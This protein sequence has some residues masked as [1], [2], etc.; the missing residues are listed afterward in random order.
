MPFTPNFVDGIG[1]PFVN[2]EMFELARQ[3]LDGA[4]VVNQEQTAAALRLVVERNRVVPE[5]A[6]ATSVAAALA[7]MAGG[8]KIAASSR[9]ATSTSPRSS[10]SSRAA[11]PTDRF[12][13]IRRLAM[14]ELTGRVAIVTGGA[15]GIGRAMSL[16]FAGAGARVVVADV[17]E[18]RGEAT[19]APCVK[20]AARRST[21]VAMFPRRMRSPQWSRGP[22]RL[23][24]RRR[25]GQ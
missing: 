20:P 4:M 25:A 18:E 22:W 15:W 8:G 23:W 2:V 9:A 11:S 13:R 6:A 5:G 7:G 19:A 21:C 12:G 16:A 24:R 3:V 10:R 14:A 17:K 1:T